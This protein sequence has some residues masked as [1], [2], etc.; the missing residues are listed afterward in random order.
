MR[1]IAGIDIGAT[2]LR[3]A[4]IR[5]DGKILEH[6][7]ERTDGKNL[8]N[9]IYNKLDSYEEFDGIGIASVGPLD[10]RNGV[11][12][13]PPN[14]E[15]RNLGI[16]K[17]LKQRYGKPCYLLNDCV[18]AVLAEQA[19]GEGKRADNLVYITFSTGIGCGV[20]VDKRAL[21]GKDGNAH[22]VGH[23][24]VDTES[25]LQCGC[26]GYGHWEAFCGGKNIPIFTRFLL[27]K[28]YKGERTALKEN[29]KSLNAELLFNLA[30]SDEIASNIVDRICRINAIEIANIINSYDPELITIGGSVALNNEAR[31][32]EAVLKYTKKYA[33]NRMPRITTTPLRDKIGIYGAA[34][35]FLYYDKSGIL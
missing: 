25:K 33:I 1:K 13:N 29:M 32:M 24:V 17:L 8:M 19:Y 20:I 5:E 9:Q 23:H 34:A 26:G 3:V 31:M 6:H 4:L 15:V 18:A 2:N 7:S 22:E 11:I 27:E 14:L 16:V 35:G 21:L 28:E 10:S 30:N 12:V